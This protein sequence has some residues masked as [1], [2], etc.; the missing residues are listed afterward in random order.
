MSFFHSNSKKSGTPK[1]TQKR[2]EELEKRIQELEIDLRGYK[3]AMESAVTKVGIVRFNP[4]QQTGSNQSFSLA[5]LDQNNNGVVLTS[6]FLK[7]YNRVYA[8]PVAKG[9]SEHM[10]SEEEKEAL[11]KALH[12]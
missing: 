2:V 12:S 9:K 5:L 7:E 6:H 1:E 11:A 3:E 10:L 8:K 4:F